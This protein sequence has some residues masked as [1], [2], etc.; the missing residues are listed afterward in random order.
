MFLLKVL[1][2][3]VYS[4][5]PQ[6][7]D[8]WAFHEEALREYRVLLHSPAQFFHDLYRN[9]YPQGYGNFLSSRNSWWKDLPGNVFLMVLS[10]FHLLSG[11]QYYSNL[12]F[13][14]LLT[15]FGPAAVYRV[16]QRRFPQQATA[17]L[18]ACFLLPSF[19]FWTSGI[20]KDGLLFTGLA[21]VFYQVAAG[22]EKGFGLKRWIGMVAGLLL[23]GAFRPFLL[24]VLLPALAAW[25]LAKRTRLRPLAAFGIVYGAGLAFFFT[26]RYLSPSLDFPAAMAEKQQAFLYL[27]GRTAVPVRPLEPSFLGFLKNAPQA[28]SLALL[29][30]FPSEIKS[31]YSLAAFLELVLLYGCF[32]LYL[33]YRKK[34]DPAAPLLLF[35]LFFSL[36][37]LLSMGYTVHFT[38]AIVRYR[39]LVLPFLLAPFMAQVDWKEVAAKVRKKY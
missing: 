10:L 28:L 37:A 27:Q 5:V 9:D 35:C 14:S 2:G 29:R 19:L 32:L 4:R 16:L 11:G 1:A 39:S 13:Y 30:P 33:F 17:L 22:F 24:L 7:V 25:F 3:I 20:H 31:G 12:I 21:L 18:A 26:A 23:V 15:F 8:T 6:L 38:G 36:S 34:E